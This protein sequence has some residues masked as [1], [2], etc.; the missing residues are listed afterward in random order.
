MT[1][2]NNIEALKI[3]EDR[4]NTIICVD[5]DD[6]IL[7]NH[8]PKLGQPIDGALSWLKKFQKEGAKLILYTMR[9]DHIIYK[10]RDGSDIFPLSEAVNYLQENG[11]QLYGVNENPSQHTWTNSPK[12]YSHI[13][14]DDRGACCPLIYDSNDMCSYVNWSIVGPRVLELIKNRKARKI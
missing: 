3:D 6:T 11:I 1:T 2:N 13:Y 8:F 14:I 12:P 5:F 4:D 9:S 7:T 10:D